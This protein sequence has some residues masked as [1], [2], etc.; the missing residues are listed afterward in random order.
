MDVTLEKIDTLRQRTGISYKEA[1][2]VLEE[3]NGDVVEAL[4]YLEENEKSFGENITNKGDEV[5]SKLKEA[6][7]KGNVT[8]VMLKKNGEVVMNIPI[9]AGAIGAVLS[10]PLTAI[11]VTAALMSGC[12]IE[13]VKE[14]GEI[15]NI[16][17]MVEKTKD[18]V[19]NVTKR[20]NENSDTEEMND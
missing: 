14:D 13:I 2:E 8:K 9:T 10:P 19:K 5:I 20:K 6:L 15:V 16:N 12:S 11:G 18:K 17:D 7:R 3:N 1:K 4:I